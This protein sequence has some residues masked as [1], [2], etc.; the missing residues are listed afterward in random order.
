M[1]LVIHVLVHKVFCAGFNSERYMYNFMPVCIG[2]SSGCIWSSY[3]LAW[4]VTSGYFNY[5]YNRIIIIVCL[6][7]SLCRCVT[8]S[9][10]ML[11]YGQSSGE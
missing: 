10:G 5:M 6:Y 9:V 4:G 2:R 8:L 7:G 3:M 1:A 11:V